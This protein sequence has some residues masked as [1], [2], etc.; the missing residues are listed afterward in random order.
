MILIIELLNK[1][2]IGGNDTLNGGRGND[3]VDGGE[4]TDVLS[5]DSGLSDSLEFSGSA[6]EFNV[7]VDGVDEGTFINIESVEFTNGDAIATQD[8]DF[9]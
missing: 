9:I 4:G 8:L 3:F 6:S 2:Y 7:F 5:F 1:C